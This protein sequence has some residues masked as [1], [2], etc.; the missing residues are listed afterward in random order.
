VIWRCAAAGRGLPGGSSLAQLLAE[1]R[2]GAILERL[3]PFQV[4]TDP[5]LADAHYQRVGAWPNHLAGAIADAA[6]EKRGWPSTKHYGTASAAWKRL[7]ASPA[8]GRAARL[9]ATSWSFRP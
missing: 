3:P 1:W 4:E 5:C 2:G 7:L 9:C 6:G 8:P